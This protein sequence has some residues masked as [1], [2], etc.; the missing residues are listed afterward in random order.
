MNGSIQVA[1]IL[2]IP[3]VVNLSWFLTLGLVTILLALGF[4]P[5][6]FEDT[7]YRDDNL[8]HWVLAAVSGVAF[9]VSIVLHELAHSV[10]ALKQGIPVKNIT[11]FIFGGVSQIGGE[12]RR[13][14]H[15]FIMALIGPLTSL[16]LSGIFFVAWWLT[17][18]ETEEPVAAVVWWLFVMNLILAAFNMAP[19]FPM[20]GGRVLRSII[21]GVTGNS[22]RATRIATLA[23]RGLGY[24]MMVVGGLAIF[25]TFGEY[26]SRWSGVWFIILGTYLENSAK[27]SWFQ[28]KAIDVLGRHFAEDLMHEELETAGK[29]ERL[30]YLASRGGPRYIFFIT[31]ENEKVV[32]VLTQR[33]VEAV[34]EMVRGT[35]TAGEVMR[36]TAQ[37]PVAM[38][39]ED[40]ASML[41]RM[42][43]ETTLHM[44][45]VRDGRVVGVVA[46]EDLLRLLAQTFFPEAAEAP[47]LPR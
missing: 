42:E 5:S 6:V 11:L 30:H 8:V 44:P 18:F 41:Q 28:A 40:A 35:T 29:D 9:F 38:P 33:E 10:V 43:Q 46:K 31:D 15:E 17:G 37:F 16:A 32:G 2:G 12:A 47:P 24:G 45:V 39:R 26:I 7:S 20:D 36:P 27:Q 34:P 23:G 19:G 25:G 21:W 14:L 3:I 1:R 22:I 13:P 4:Y